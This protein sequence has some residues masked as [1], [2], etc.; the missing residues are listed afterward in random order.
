[1][2]RNEELLRRR[3]RVVARGV[4]RMNDAVAATARGAKITDLEGRE[5]ID[6]AGGIGTLN[7]GHCP[8][9]VVRAIQEQAE[10][11]LHTCIHVTTY[12]PYVALCEKLVELFPHGDETRAMLVN[13]GAEAVENAIKIARLATG[14]PALLCF[15]EAFHGRTL[16]GLTLTSKT[17]YKKGAG[18]FAPEVYRLPFPNYYRYNDGLSR[19][20]FVK[21]EIQRLEE[22]FV[23][24][25]PAERVAAVLIE[26][27]QGEGGFAPAP[28]EYLRALRRICDEHGMLLIVDEVQSGFG[29]T[30]R[31][32]A[33]EHAGITPDLSTWAKS[34]GSGMPISAVVGRREFM[35]APAPG[36]LGGTYGGN[37][38]ACA[39]A[40]AS[41]QTM[42]ELD[43]NRRAEEIGAKILARFQ[44]LKERCS[45][46]GDA[47]GVGAMCA[48]EFV[49]DDDPHRPAG[50]LVGRI[51]RACFERGVLVI[52]AGS[53]G[54]VIRILAPLVIPDGEL[55]RGLDVL[56]EEILRVAGT[57]ETTPTS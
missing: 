46:I 57:P 33:Y 32:A 40:L 42:E 24:T 47:R 25:I 37:P 29:R 9:A 34:L 23:N 45:S 51:V 52:P 27:V 48:L 38:V 50:E 53:Y 14:R 54:N 3:E 26:P 6:F 5:L 10:K 4:A 7:A 43:L 49:H 13:S 15:T 22:S 41:I 56:E 18:P 20:E 21:R 19:E 17:G 39:A 36:Q 28:A 35:D 30:G 44:S 31:W 16:L 55:E 2:D 1:M 11:L 12:E 8:E